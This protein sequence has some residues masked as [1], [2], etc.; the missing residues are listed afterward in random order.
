MTRRRGLTLWGLLW[1][2][3]LGFG[4]LI[5]YAAIGI[6]VARVKDRDWADVV[7]PPPTGAG[8]A[9]LWLCRQPQSGRPYATWRDAAP[10]AGCR[11]PAGQSH[12]F[13]FLPSY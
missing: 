8:G 12:I 5:A 4:A 6:Q 3:V 10:H 9:L 13:W 2:I 1:T 11:R 7:V